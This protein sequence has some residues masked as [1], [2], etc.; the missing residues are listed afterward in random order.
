M[1]PRSKPNPGRRQGIPNDCQ[2][3]GPRAHW[4]PNRTAP[5]D[6][7][8]VGQPRLLGLGF[9]AYATAMGISL[10]L[11]ACELEALRSITRLRG[12]HVQRQLTQV[13]AVM[14]SSPGPEGAGKKAGTAS[15]P[16]SQV[17][18]QLGHLFNKP[19]VDLRRKRYHEFLDDVLDEV[20]THSQQDSR[21]GR[22]L[23][24]SPFHLFSF[25]LLFSSIFFDIFNCILHIDS[26][27]LH[28]IE[29]TWLRCS[30]P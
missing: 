29:A 25:I 27:S 7:Q 2:G 6:C 3:L 15:N 9:K 22:V 10:S 14:A 5:N 21:E 30:I 28:L 4:Q 11:D 1:P 26:S 13:H 16:P 17:R 24:V 20:T 23:P 18:E 8:W 19:T 12:R